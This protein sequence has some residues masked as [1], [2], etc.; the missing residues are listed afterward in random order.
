MNK[1]ETLIKAEKERY[2][3]AIDKIL[4]DLKADVVA[5]LKTR[6]NFMVIPADVDINV[7]IIDGAGRD[8][9]YRV[10]AVGL[11][12]GDD[13]IYVTSEALYQEYDTSD[14][15]VEDVKRS[16]FWWTFDDC[17]LKR[18]VRTNKES[19]LNNVYNILNDENNEN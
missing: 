4:D 19:I 7:R 17:T 1:Y 5:A 9:V 6:G 8:E 14:Y 10:A 12:K 18:Y 3:V 11:T 15:S 2:E 16:N 13:V